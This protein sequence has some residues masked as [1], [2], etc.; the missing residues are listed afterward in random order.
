[1]IELS[2]LLIAFNNE[3]HIEETLE[4]LISQQCSFNYEIVVGDDCSTDKT[5]EIIKQYAKN[6]PKLFNVEQNPSQLGILKNFKTTLDRCNGDLI[7]NFDGDD[8]VQSKEA[9]EKL[10]TVLRLNPDLGFVDSGFDCYITDE[11][12]LIKFWNKKI[13]LAA[14][15]AAEKIGA[16]GILLSSTPLFENSSAAFIAKNLTEAAQWILE[17]KA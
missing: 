16:K 6:Y 12:A 11:N 8:V 7:F 9:L 5:F 4:S 14:N 2:V 13:I 10:A 1:M 3:K 15:S 17:R